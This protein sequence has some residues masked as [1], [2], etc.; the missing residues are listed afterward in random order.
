MGVEARE[1]CANVLDETGQREL[2]AAGAAAALVPPLEHGRLQTC[3]GEVAPDDGGVVSTAHDYRI[4]FLV[5]HRSLLF[6]FV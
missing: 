3:A 2:F 6:R 1:V 4:I 5:C